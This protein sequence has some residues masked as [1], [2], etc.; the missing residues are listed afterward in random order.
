[1]TSSER[2]ESST[3]TEKREIDSY[4]S[5]L[6]PFLDDLANKLAERLL[7]SLVPRI[8]AAVTVQPRWLSLRSAAAYIDK[9]YK[10]M[11]YTL[12]QFPRELPIVRLGDMPRIDIQD[13]DR[14][15]LNRKEK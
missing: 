9:T 13:L 6:D 7:R 11:R 12:A 1:M 5:S 15:M 8:E 4:G 14:F 2:S 10:G 3:E